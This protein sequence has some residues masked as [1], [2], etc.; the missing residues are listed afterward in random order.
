MEYPTITIRWCEEE[1]ALDGATRMIRVNGLKKT[2]YFSYTSG[3]PSGGC[4][5][6]AFSTTSSVAL[7]VGSNTIQASICNVSAVCTTVTFTVQRT[8]TGGLPPILSVYP[9]AA[10]LQDYGRCAA[11]CFAATYAQSTVPYFSLDAAR[12]VTLAYNS[13]RVDPKPFVHVD[14]QHGDVPGNLPSYFLMKVRYGQTDLTFLNGET[15][16]RFAAQASVTLRLGAQFNAAANGMSATGVY[17]VTIIVGAQYPDGGY[18]ESSVVTR[19]IVVNQTSSPIARGWTVPGIQRAHVQG[20]GSVLITEGDGSATYFLKPSGFLPPEGDFST[21]AVTGSGSGTVY[22]RRYPD[23]T[24][25]TFNYLGSMVRHRNR[26]GDSTTVF[27]NGTQLYQI[28]DP[29]GNNIT[30]S[31]GANGLGS[32][33]D[34]AGRFTNVR[35]DASQNITAIVDPDGDSTRFGYTSNRLISIT[36]RGGASRTLGYNANSGK[37]DSLTTPAV[38]IVNANGSLS[39]VPLIARQANWQQVG[40]PYGST[41]TPVTAPRADTVRARIT[42]R[43]GAV[44]AL[45]VNRFGS[46]VEVINALGQ[47]TTTVYEF[48]GLPLRVTRPSAGVDSVTFPPS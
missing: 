32:I 26:W 42:E 48:N 24:N 33:E 21:L 11:A 37:L 8:G 45:R 7:V 38:E 41:G 19:V 17:P 29:L 34:P 3:S 35:V 30:F 40:V 39:T 46:P 6:K 15:A 47:V 2:A 28:R 18:S 27:H 1:V 23:S 13:D 14:V 12:N 4:Q 5:Y 44:T 16:L 36:A 43:G 25:V 31:Y 10:D 22:T 9:Y 20:D